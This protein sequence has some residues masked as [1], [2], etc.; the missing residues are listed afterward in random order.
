LIGKLPVYLAKSRGGLGAMISKSCALRY[1][2]VSLS[3]V[4]QEAAA[5][6]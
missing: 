6:K 4:A 1:R 3:A 5:A 2:G